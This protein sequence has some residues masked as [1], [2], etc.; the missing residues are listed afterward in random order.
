MIMR[1]EEECLPYSQMHRHLLDLRQY[2]DGLDCDGITSVLSDAV[3]GFGGHE[4]RY[5]HL[6][7]KQGTKTLVASG[8][9]VTNIK[10]LF[11]DKA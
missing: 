5:D 6:W 2:C 7:R 9:S 1:A 11:P 10:E 8:A 3:S 4:I